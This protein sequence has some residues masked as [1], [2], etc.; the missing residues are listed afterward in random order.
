M[1][2]SH[3]LKAFDRDLAELDAKIMRMGEL[4]EEEL[5]GALKALRKRDPEKAE[6][7]IVKDRQVDSL[8]QNIED[9]TVRIIIRHQPLADDLRQVIGAMKTAGE[10]ERIGDLAK[11][12]ARR[13]I[14]LASEK[15][16]KPLKKGLK[17][18]GKQVIAQLHDVLEAYATRDAQKAVEV[19]RRDEEID[20][21]YNALF[22][23]L[24][25][26]MMEDPRTIGLCTHL[27]F[28]ARNLE[29]IGDHVTNIAENVYYMVTGDKLDASRPKSD[30]TANILPRL[31]D[32][33]D[34]EDED[35]F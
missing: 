5:K 3:I 14:T 30:A 9:D 4:A 6:T 24:L 31:D 28:G 12:I 8:E 16:P 33:D 11:N 22:R 1:P 19:W 17:R 18:M 20:E 29:R 15:P 35:D 7:V 21:A 13:V 23:E 25:T 32:E 34:E 27:L 10:L 2:H 26:Y